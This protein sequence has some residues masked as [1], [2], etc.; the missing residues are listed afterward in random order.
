MPACGDTSHR[1]SPRRLT[2][3]ECRAWL[4]DHH[5]GRLGYQSGRGPRC[6]VVSYALAG[7]QVLVQVPDYNEIAHYAPGAEVAFEVDGRQADHRESV[8]VRGRAALAGPASKVDESAFTEH[9]PAGVCTSVVCLPLSALEGYE[10]GL[11]VG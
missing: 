9:W 5:E 2:S 7:D 6:V 8:R 10:D 11:P 4:A 3:R 1:P